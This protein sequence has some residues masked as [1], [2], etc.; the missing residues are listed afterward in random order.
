MQQLEFEIPEDKRIIILSLQPDP[1]REILE[2]SKK[3]E[4]RRKFLST[5]V[6]AFIYVS[7]PI[8]EIT[9]YIEF[10]KPIIDKVENIGRI[11]ELE[12][13]GSMEGISRYMNGLETGF[14]IPI[15][16]IREIEPLTLEELRKTYRFTA[17]QSYIHL[18]SNP[19]LKATLIQRLKAAAEMS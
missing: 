1:Y 6:N 13:S 2:G 16:S 5:S 9:A 17:P 12:G 19:K 15:I 14:A 11:A 4:F 18:E 3:H 10:G 8:K 7:S